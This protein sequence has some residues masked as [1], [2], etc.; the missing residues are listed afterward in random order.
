MLLHSDLLR[1][2]STAHAGGGPSTSPAFT[3]AV[4]PGHTDLQRPATS[5]PVAR[6]ASD[7][8]PRA[9]LSPAQHN[10]KEESGQQAACNDLSSLTGGGRSLKSRLC[11]F[12]RSP[13]RM[14]LGLYDKQLT[15]HILFWAA[16]YSFSHFPVRVSWALRLGN[17]KPDSLP[18]LQE[19]FARPSPAHPSNT[20]SFLLLP[21]ATG[22]A[23]P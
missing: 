9:H 22:S 3:P 14:N 15:Y 16:F 5:F 4:S 20:F 19:P 17:D 18:G 12:P 2:P 11:T 6:S 23:P 8:H 21:P 7:T 1:K 13:S 10:S